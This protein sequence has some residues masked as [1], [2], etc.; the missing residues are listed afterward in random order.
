M[1][2]LWWLILMEQE[3]INLFVKTA[4]ACLLFGSLQTQGLL[5]RRYSQISSDATCNAEF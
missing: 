2:L 3:H 1:N 5:L 4:N